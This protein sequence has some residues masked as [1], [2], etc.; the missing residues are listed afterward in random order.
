M[1]ET[2]RLDEIFN[3]ENVDVIVSYTLRA[4]LW[5]LPNYVLT[6]LSRF[7]CHTKAVMCAT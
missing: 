3:T 6:G 5:L 7:I 2:P 1:V 4:V